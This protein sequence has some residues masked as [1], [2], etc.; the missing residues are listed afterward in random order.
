MNPLN[1]F[2][3]DGLLRNH[4]EAV[5]RGDIEDAAEALKY[6]TQ[7]LINELDEII[8]RYEA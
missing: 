6:A 2:A 4:D 8:K 1:Q 7:V 3:L 5:E